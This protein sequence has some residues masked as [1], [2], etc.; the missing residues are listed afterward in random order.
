MPGGANRQRCSACTDGR[1]PPPTP[2][3]ASPVLAPVLAV[4]RHF[5]VHAP[6]RQG[7]APRSGPRTRKPRQAPALQDDKGRPLKYRRL[8]KRVSK[9]EEETRRRHAEHLNSVASTPPTLTLDNI[10]GLT[11]R[12]YWHRQCMQCGITTEEDE[13]GFSAF[14]RW[15]NQWVRLHGSYHAYN[16]SFA[17]TANRTY[18]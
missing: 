3:D 6:R 17:M 18:V 7:R 14:D 4:R 9:H 12:P 10:R 13:R 11:H 5:G 8:G 1:C 16:V 2:N 15:N